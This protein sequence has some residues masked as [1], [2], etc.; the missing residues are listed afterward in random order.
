MHAPSIDSRAQSLVRENNMDSENPREPRGEGR[1]QPRAH[2]AF[3]L[4]CAA[5]GLAILAPVFVL[6]ALAI[7]LDDRGPVFYVQPRVGR[8]P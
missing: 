8:G 2:R 7:Y 1:P 4:F 3:D 5:A 6:I